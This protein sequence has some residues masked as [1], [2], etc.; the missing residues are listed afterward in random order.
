MTSLPNSGYNMAT[1]CQTTSQPL[2]NPK[3]S[4]NYTNN[5]DNSNGIVHHTIPYNKFVQSGYS[6]FEFWLHYCNSKKLTY[7]ISHFTTMHFEQQA[8]TLFMQEFY[9]LNE[10]LQFMHECICKKMIWKPHCT[11]YDTNGQFTPTFVHFCSNWM[12][13]IYHLLW[14]IKDIELNK[15]L[16]LVLEQAALSKLNQ[17]HAGRKSIYTVKDLKWHDTSFL[18]SPFTQVNDD[19]QTKDITI[20]SYARV[21]TSEIINEKNE[22]E[23]K[24]TSEMDR[25]DW[26][27]NEYE[28]EMK[29]DNNEVIQQQIIQLIEELEHIYQIYLKKRCEI[30]E[31][32]NKKDKEKIDNDIQQQ[33]QLLEVKWKQ[34]KQYQQQPQDITVIQQILWDIMKFEKNQQ[35]INNSIWQIKMKQAQ[36][37][38][39]QMQ[40]QWQQKI[41]EEK[42]KN[43]SKNPIGS[44]NVQANGIKNN[45]TQ[46]SISSLSEKF[47]HLKVELEEQT[48]IVQ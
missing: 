41:Q 26:F 42:E 25:D 40:Q 30:E 17:L 36:L 5:N 18:P 27:I 45:A 48:N 29:N 35:M 15:E 4:T 1:Y 6:E 38:F 8:N 2:T 20:R 47:N 19:K 37:H 21:K 16:I 28:K 22:T 34:L 9:S 11:A 33:Q 7:P 46:P 23:K 43:I 44:T 3:S 31:I 24:T 39:Q 10:A 14:Y 13:I 12:A 32:E